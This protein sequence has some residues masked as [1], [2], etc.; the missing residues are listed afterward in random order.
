MAGEQDDILPFPVRGKLIVRLV[1]QLGDHSHMEGQ[2]LFNDETRSEICDCVVKGAD[3]ASIGIS[4]DEFITFAG[5]EY[6]SQR[7]TQYLIN[8]CLYFQIIGVNFVHRRPR[9]NNF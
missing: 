7:G 5:L 3:F 8:D 6:D 4:V 2:Y 9:N 1:N